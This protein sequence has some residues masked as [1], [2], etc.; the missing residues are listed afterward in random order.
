MRKPD[1]HISKEELERE[2]CEF[3][4][5]IF[6]PAFDRVGKDQFERAIERQVILAPQ[7]LKVARLVARGLTNKEIGTQLNFTEDGAKQHVEAL[8]LKAN[9]DNRTKLAQWFVGL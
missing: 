6:P 5:V 8:M 7:Q 4:G 3:L 9:V 1:D 2:H